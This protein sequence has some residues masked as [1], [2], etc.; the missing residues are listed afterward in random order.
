MHI[1]QIPIDSFPTEDAFFATLLAETR[2]VSVFTPNPEMLLHARSD[3]DFARVLASGD[4]RIPD[5]IGLYLAYQI[6][7]NPHGTLVNI[8]LL[9]YYIFRLFF[10]RAALYRR[11]GVRICG[12]DLTH[13][14]LRYVG[15]HGLGVTILDQYCPGDTPKEAVQSTLVDTMRGHFP[16][17]T[18]HLVLAGAEDTASIIARIRESG[19]TLILS[20]LGM[21]RQERSI[22][23]IL[24]HVPEVRWG[25]AVGSSIDYFTGFQTRA[26]EV[27]RRI[28]FEWLYRLVCGRRRWYRLRRIY[29][30]T[31]LF[32][33]AVLASKG[34]IPRENIK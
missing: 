30:A 29:R 31:V 27:W 26:P 10:Q 4:Y 20:T 5:G 9:P 2:P 18:F 19:D 34:P 23:D 11:Y 17:A 6:L 14:F 15:G 16:G 24:P 21:G 8:F 1:F 22:Q 7:D 25:L 12:S 32:L 3:P 13:R 28:G 33:L